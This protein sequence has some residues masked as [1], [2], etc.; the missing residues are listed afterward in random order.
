MDKKKI[1][2]G[3][4][5]ALA[6]A[7][8]VYLAIAKPWKKKEEAP[9]AEGEVKQEV[10]PTKEGPVVLKKAAPKKT[11]FGTPTPTPSKVPAPTPAPASKGGKNLWVF[12]KTDGVKS[13]SQSKT[14]GVQ[15][16]PQY[17]SYN[18]GKIIGK[19]TGSTS[20]GG[21][22]YLLVNDSGKTIIVSENLTY[23]KY[24]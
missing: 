9:A 20:I 17:N 14:K 3:I 22:K 2:I 7:A 12:S 16:G 8:G 4:G 10:G 6:A 13:Y 5:V 11:S 19:F 23:T 18:K 24:Q 15:L 21:Q 1:F